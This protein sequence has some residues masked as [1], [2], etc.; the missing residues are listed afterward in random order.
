MRL[1]VLVSILAL[2]C[3]GEI[4]RLGPVYI[5]GE[6]TLQKGEITAGASWCDFA[7]NLPWLGDQIMPILGCPVEPLGHKP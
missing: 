7:S 2:G 3:A 1:L 6:A 4:A 5:T